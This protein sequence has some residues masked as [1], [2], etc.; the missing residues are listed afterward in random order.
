MHSVY[1]KINEDN[2]IIAINSSAFIKKP[3][4]W[5]KIDEGIGDKFLHAQNNYLDFPL[6]DENGNYCYILQDQKIVYKKTEHEDS[7]EH[8]ED[9]FTFVLELLAEHEYR[10]CLLELG[11]TEYDL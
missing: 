6:I 11:V 2:K 3:L 10:L 5:I 1:I 7:V 4:D 8:Q 9:D